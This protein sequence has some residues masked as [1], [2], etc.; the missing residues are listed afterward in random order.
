MTTT[1]P[2][3]QNPIAPALP[4]LTPAAELALLARILHREGYDDHLAGHITYAQPDGTLLVNPMC[5][6]WDELRAADSLLPGRRGGN[7]KD[8][9]ED[10]Q[11]RLLAEAKEN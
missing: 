9:T 5:L 11:A 1:A 7:L 4:P 2:R 10:E 6:T 3:T 8:F